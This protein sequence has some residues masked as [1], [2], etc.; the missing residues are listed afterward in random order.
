MMTSSATEQTSAQASA[1]VT[2]SIKGVRDALTVRRVY[3]DPYDVEGAM[4]IPVARVAG[5]AGGGGGEGPEE[6]E[7]KGSGFGTG[8]GL[9]ATP[10]GVYEV[11]DGS[12]E[13]KPAI[14]VNVIARGGQILAGIITICVTLIVWSRSR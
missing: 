3:G 9:A 4:V 10:V 7:D 14:D 6:G 13:W 8:F 12:V 1:V 5:G 11:K 2:D